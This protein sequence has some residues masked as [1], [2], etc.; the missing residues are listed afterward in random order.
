MTECVCLRRVY[1]MEVSQGL[2]CWAMILSLCLMGI[3]FDFICNFAYHLRWNLSINSN[4]LSSWASIDQTGLKPFFIWPTRFAQSMRI[5]ES[6]ISIRRL[7]L[8]VF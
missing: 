4:L 5:I 8:C 2:T 3:A 1:D 6:Y 7:Q